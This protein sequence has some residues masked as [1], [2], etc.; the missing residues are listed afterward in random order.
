MSLQEKVLNLKL[1]AALAV[2]HAQGWQRLI[3]LYGEQKATEFYTHL[4]LNHLEKKSIEWEGLKLSR[5]P[6]EHEKIAVKGI[7]VAQE[8]SK[9]AIGKI[10]LSLR[11]ELISDGLKGIKKLKPATYHELTLQA[12]KESRTELRHRLI[13]VHAQG[14][15]LVVHE[16]SGHKHLDGVWPHECPIDFSTKEA[17]PEDEFDDL[18]MLTDLTSSRVANDVQ[19]RIIDAATRHALLGQ[20]GAGL[21]NA[22]TNEITG[23]SVT[24]IDRAARGLANK[25]I[26]IG[27][28]DEAESRKDDWDRVEYSA[29]LDA[30]VCEPC[31]S[32]DGKTAPEEDDLQPAPNPECLGGDM[33]RCFH[34]WI[35]Q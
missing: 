24:Y 30:N 1:N 6:K 7:A 32:Q 14:R 16:L 11:E 10:L 25:V 27:R 28:S 8:S 3:D 33:C 34:V 2:K 4:G 23:G 29:L 31:A 15:N 18:D 9:E 22:V 35:N 19:S 21:I 5:E 20:T 26:N 13:K 12:P 17:L